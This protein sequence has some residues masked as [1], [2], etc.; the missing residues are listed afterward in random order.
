MSESKKDVLWYFISVIFNVAYIWYCVSMMNATTTSFLEDG[1]LDVIEVIRSSPYFAVFGGTL[2]CMKYSVKHLTKRSW[3]WRWL[4]WYLLYPVFAG[5]MGLAVCAF[6]LIVMFDYD[7]KYQVGT[8]IRSMVVDPY[9]ALTIFISCMFTGFYVVSKKHFDSWDYEDPLVS[10]NQIKKNSHNTSF[11]E[12]K[13][14][15]FVEILKRFFAGPVT[16]NLHIELP[17]DENDTSKG[18]DNDTDKSDFETDSKKK[19]A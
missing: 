12:T 5:M 7:A 2:Y 8:D 1:N 16:M 18:E 15:D 13:S 19:V 17:K 4:P 3:S 6:F 11:N 10:D 9:H 14:Q